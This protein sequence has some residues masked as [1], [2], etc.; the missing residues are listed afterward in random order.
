MLLWSFVRNLVLGGGSEDSLGLHFVLLQNTTTTSITS[1]FCFLHECSNDNFLYFQLHA[2][3]VTEDNLEWTFDEDDENYTAQEQRVEDNE[4]NDGLIQQVIENSN[5]AITNN[6]DNIR[7]ISSST[8]DSE[9]PKQ[10]PSSPEAE[11]D[12]DDD[13]DIHTQ[14]MIEPKCYLILPPTI[15]KQ[16]PTHVNNGRTE[17]EC[18]ICFSEYDVGD[19]V[20][21]SKYCCHA[22]HQECVLDWFSQDKTKCPSCR[23]IFWEPRG[24]KVKKRSG[25]VLGGSGDNGSVGDEGEERENT[26]NANRERGDTTDTADMTMSDP[27]TNGGSSFDSEGSSTTL[28]PV[29]EDSAVVEEVTSG[30]SALAVGN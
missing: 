14:I 27:S 20:I 16:F 10:R 21:C 12:D 5:N 8:N 24:D 6:T 26:S 30:L 18:A 11:E 13:D 2:Q 25:G 15:T 17:N 28:G 29:V 4:D 3:V 22:F 7:S 23:S 19:V 1:C 9:S